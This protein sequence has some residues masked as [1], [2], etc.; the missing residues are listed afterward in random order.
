MRSV[1]QESISINPLP[2]KKTRLAGDAFPNDDE[3]ADEEKEE[4]MLEESSEVDQYLLLPKFS[5]GISFDL[6]AWWKN[7]SKM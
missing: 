3:E 2:A 4:I 5:E 7:N 6:L 1:P